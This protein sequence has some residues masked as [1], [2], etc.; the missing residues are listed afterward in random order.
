MLI[1]ELTAAAAQLP[2]SEFDDQS[3]I[4]ST[5]RQS[6]YP[7]CGS[8]ACALEASVAALCVVQKPTLVRREAGAHVRRR[9]G[10]GNAAQA[11]G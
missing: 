2:T 4:F 3:V 9:C 8:A 11:P 5:K 7:A 6:P 10:C 1:G